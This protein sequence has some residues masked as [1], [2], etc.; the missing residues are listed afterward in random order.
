MFAPCVGLLGVVFEL[1]FDD[2]DADGL[3]GGWFGV[4]EFVTTEELCVWDM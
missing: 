4:K 2:L 1:L 3:E